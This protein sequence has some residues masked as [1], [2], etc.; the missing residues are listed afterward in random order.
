M[1]K[2]EINK[3][4]FELKTEEEIIEFVNNRLN[5]L[6]TN[7][8]EKTV[9]QNYTDSFQ[10][11]ISQKIHYKAA[12]KFDDSECPD[13][14][15]DDITPYINLIKEI[16]K[17]TGYN[18]LTLFTTI[19]FTV[20]KYL[21][22]E[23]IGLGRYMTYTSYK[24]K[25]L[26]IK[27]ISKNGI[28]FC[29]EK[30][31]MAHNMFKFLGIDSEVVCGARDTE[32]H[33]YN[34]VYPNGYENEPMVLFDPSHFLNFIKDNNKAS[35]GFYKAFKKQDY[36]TLKDGTPI[37]IDLT[38]TEETYRKL[39]GYNGSLDDYDFEY[40]KPTYVYGLENANNYK[41]SNSNKK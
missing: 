16:K 14:V 6:E 9:G 15:Y 5:E 22:S 13:L 39:Y 41:K 8:K 7:S 23:D 12:E 30:S 11:Y 35:Y 34:F 26:S 4:I 40:E 33:A 24:G 32:I 31:G 17:G 1:T 38:K 3:R 37:Q 2:E 20:Y 28:A 36:E 19:F 10:D 29:S 25:K 27:T 21:P 18:E